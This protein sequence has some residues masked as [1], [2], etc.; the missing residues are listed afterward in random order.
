MSCPENVFDDWWE[1]A[2]DAK[3]PALLQNNF[4]EGCHRERDITFYAA[5]LQDIRGIEYIAS[6]TVENQVGKERDFI[7][8]KVNNFGEEAE[9]NN[10]PEGPSPGIYLADQTPQPGDSA[11][12]NLVTSEPYY[13]VDWYVKA[14]WE[15]GERGTYQE[16]TCGDGTSTIASFSYTF[17]SG[18]MHTGD[19]LITAVIYRWSDMS[20]YEETYAVTVDMTPN[21]DDCTDGNSNCPNASAH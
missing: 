5:G 8:K 16:G 4:T 17:P 18:I 20:T 13:W 15:S 11:T 19:F 9:D 1:A 3:T 2:F 7:K 10:V 21:C 6:A 14:P 12:L